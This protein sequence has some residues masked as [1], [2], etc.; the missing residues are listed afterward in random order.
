MEDMIPIPAIDIQNGKCVRLQKGDLE[1]T[2]I[3]FE[4]PTAAAEHWVKLG[5]KRIHLVDLD[6]AYEGKSSNFPIIEKIK[7][8]F[9][10]TLFQLGGGIRNL[11]TLKNYENLGIDY[12]I[13]GSVAIIDKDFFSNACEVYSEKIILGLDAK[14]GFVATEAWTKT[15]NV[16]ATDL[17]EE[18]KELPI[19]QI[20]YT[21]IDKD[22]MMMG[23]NIEETKKLAEVSRFPVIASGGIS[24]LEDLEKLSLIKNIYGAIC[25]K[26]LYEGSI[27]LKEILERFN[28]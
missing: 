17:V 26:A 22:G 24:R 2:K 20:I 15:S 18:F 23:P 1:S 5:A 13:L 6:G 7:K 8:T 14:E 10:D 12:F 28:S 3:Y 21:D 4:D 27:N 11:E 9:P 25:G 19:F 16:L